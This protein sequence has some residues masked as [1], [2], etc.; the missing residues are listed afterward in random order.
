MD[1][2][3]SKQDRFYNFLAWLHVNRTRVLIVAAGAV[4]IASV[5]GFLTWNKHHQEDVASEALSEI[6]GSTR[7]GTPAPAGTAEAYL[8]VANSYPNT[9]AGARAL[10][11]AA[12]TFFDEQ[13]Y[14]EA[15]QQFEKFARAYPDSPWRSQAELGI[16]V[17]L[18]SPKK[19]QAAADKY[20]EIIKRYANE[21]AADLAR[22][23]LAR[24]QEQLGKPDL[25]LRY[26]Q[27][28]VKANPYTSLG[29][30]AG[31]QKQQ[32]LEKHPELDETNKIVSPKPNVLLTPQASATNAAKTNASTVKATNPPAVKIP[33]PANK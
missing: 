28:L 6:K 11:L 29:S 14:E 32:I 20:D 23:E 12:S 24:W 3:V 26:Y 13:K 18:D 8:K 22:L 25:A 17:C 10:L 16:A 19:T 21:P 15:K 30:E 1:A 4:L 5:V 9:A 7:A 2:E 33:A 27:E 31:V